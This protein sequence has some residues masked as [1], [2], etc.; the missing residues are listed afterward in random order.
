MGLLL[1]DNAL[2]YPQRCQTPDTNI[3]FLRGT[4]VKRTS[5]L[6]GTMGFIGREFWEGMTTLAYAARATCPAW[7]AVDTPEQLGREGNLLFILIFFEIVDGVAW[8]R[9]PCHLSTAETGSAFRLRCNLCVFSWVS[10]RGYDTCTL[11]VTETL[12]KSSSNE[13]TLNVRKQRTK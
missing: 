9:Y 2:G 4:A 7:W 3:A 8:K 12:A 10:N 5:S 6:L 13:W 11:R 1:P